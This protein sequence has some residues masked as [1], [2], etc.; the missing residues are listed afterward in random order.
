MRIAVIPARG[1]SKR[2]PRKNIRMF[3]GKPMIAWSIKA[4]IESQCFDEIIVSTDDD[5]IAE[6]ARKYG[7][8]VPFMRPKEL[9]DDYAS[10][11]QVV[12]HALEWYE[13]TGNKVDQLCCI[14]ATAPFVDAKDISAGLE[15]LIQEDAD[16]AISITSFPFPIQRALTVSD[17]NRLNMFQPEHALTRSQDLEEAWHDVGQFYWG[18]RSAWREE[19]PF[20]TAASIGIPIPRYRAQDIDTEED[21]VM[22]ERLSAINEKG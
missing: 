16:Y 22:A 8:V 5:E 18:K 19:K 14:Y 12:K 10:T 21:W 13:S 9:A 15:L 6:T 17:S 20:F 4:A 3:S 7:A 11:V 1:G 2:I